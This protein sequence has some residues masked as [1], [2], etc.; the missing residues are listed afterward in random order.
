MN[1]NERT[2]QDLLVYM[3]NSQCINCTHIIINDIKRKAR[4]LRKFRQS[5][6]ISKSQE[7]KKIDEIGNAYL[8]E[9]EDIIL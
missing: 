8:N 6:L 2:M 1:Q 3:L 7:L 5:V 9:E 4:N